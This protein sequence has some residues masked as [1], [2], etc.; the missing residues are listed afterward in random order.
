MSFE[1]SAADWVAWTRTPG[2]DSYWYHREAFFDLLPPPGRAALDV[3][4]GEGRVCRDLAAR[5]YDVTALDLAPSLLA[6][7]READPAGRYVLGDAARLP[8]ADA[9]FDL[10]V[11]Y[12]SLMDVEDMPGAVAE[13]ARVLEAGGALCACVTHPL[14]DA[15]RF[16]SR[17]PDAS[18]VITGSYFG[19]RHCGGTFERNGLSLTLWSW[20]Y[21]LEAYADALED[22]GLLIEAMREPAPT[23]DYRGYDQRSRVPNFLML[24]ASKA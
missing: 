18:F 14:S 1:G 6:A 10:V 7:A 9:S 23:R 19:R 24:R 8:F 22:A 21:P 16:E 13:M 3:G 11:A 20:C 4:C 5:G 12:N 15:G 2:H 17:E